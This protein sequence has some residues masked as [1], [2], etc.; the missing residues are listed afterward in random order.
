MFGFGGGC[1]WFRVL[2]LGLFGK[3]LLVGFKVFAAVFGGLL[4]LVG[5]RWFSDFLVLCS[6]IYLAGFRG[7]CCVCWVWWFA[8][9][10]VFR[11]LCS[12]QVCLIVLVV[13]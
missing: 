7:L 2:R 8:G 6:V 12:A 11:G 1:W 4:C 10:W 5:V 13:A 3:L 9:F